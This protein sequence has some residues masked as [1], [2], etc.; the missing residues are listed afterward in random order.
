MVGLAL[1]LRPEA[2]LHGVK[3]SALCPG[4]VET[5]ILD[6]GPADD[7]PTMATETVTAR[8]YLTLLKQKPVAAD[9]S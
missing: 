7:I 9:R 4:A 8:Q 6:R 5:P 2:A 3:V 1:G